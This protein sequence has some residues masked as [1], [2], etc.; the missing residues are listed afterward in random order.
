M[1]APFKKLESVSTRFPWLV[2][3]LLPLPAVIAGFLLSML[4]V[5]GLAKLCGFGIGASAAAAPDWFRLAA[6]AL[7]FTAKFTMMPLTMLLLTVLVWRQRL[8]ILWLLPG[9]LILLPL[10]TDVVGDFPTAAE[11]LQHKKTDFHIGIGW[12]WIW[13]TGSGL[14]PDQNA[15]PGRLGSELQAGIYWG[16]ARQLLILVPPAALLWLR[17]RQ[18]KDAAHAI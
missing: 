15:L 18:Q 14:N 11:I 7:L 10:V 12:S 2:F 1:P 4:L 13:S 9:L 17:L 16:L 8:S 6:A 3:P 5:M